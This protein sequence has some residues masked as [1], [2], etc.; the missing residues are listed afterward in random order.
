MQVAVAVAVVAAAVVAVGDAGFE[1]DAV[2]A[3]GAVAAVAEAAAA[4]EV[5]A[6]AVGAA[7]ADDGCDCDCDCDGDDDFAVL[8]RSR[9]VAYR[10]LSPAAFAPTRSSLVEARSVD[11]YWL[12]RGRDVAEVAC[13][14]NFARSLDSLA[15]DA[16]AS[17]GRPLPAGNRGGVCSV[18]VRI[19]T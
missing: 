13:C 7:L 16:S 6:V 4:V 12:S 19:A 3:L 15:F 10:G 2:A 14:D 5:V 17:S 8:S 9:N 1:I 11:S 18:R